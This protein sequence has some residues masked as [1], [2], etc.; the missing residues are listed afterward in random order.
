MS[1][2][3]NEKQK[4]KSLIFTVV[5]IGFLFIT[6]LFLIGSVWFYLDLVILIVMM[7]RLILELL[8]IMKLTSKEDK[9]KIKKNTTSTIVREIEIIKIKELTYEN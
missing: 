3:M 9:N 2:K 4:K 5:I 7:I 6:L 1:E 8:K